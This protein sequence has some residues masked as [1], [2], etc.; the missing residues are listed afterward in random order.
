M[1]ITFPHLGNSY[2]AIETLLRTL[3]HEP[4]TPPLGTRKTLELGS[5]ISPEHTCLPFK[6]ILGNM[7]EGIS[8][9]ADTV[10]MIGGWGPCRLGYY[11]EIQRILL[12]ESGNDI[13]FITLEV[14]RK[15]YNKAWSTMRKVFSCKNLGAIYKGCQLTKAKMDVLERLENLSLYYRPREKIPGAI[16]SFL[17]KKLQ[18]LRQVS[19]IKDCYLI[20]ENSEKELEDLINPNNKRRVPRVGFLG[21]IYTVVEPFANLNIETRLGHLGVEVVRTISLWEWLQDH[22]F[23]KIMGKSHIE[24]LAK[25]ADGYLRG[26][27]GGHGLESVAHSVEL[28]KSNLDGII[29][30]LPLSC[31]PE[32]IAQGILPKISSD[33]EVPIMSLVIDEHAGETGF[34][35]RL[36]AFVDLM[37]RRLY[38]RV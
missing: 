7:L 3:G 15:D 23:K 4:I 21:E 35:T 19:S 12:E 36:E 8:Q 22:I 17:D 24:P 37:E 5:K 14:P 9:G 34:Q 27:I 38:A 18:E 10:M 20:Y 29:H 13:E 30:I 11:G 28:A 2:I 16:S 26:F 31:N 33:Y 6:I 1:K 32:I 25:S